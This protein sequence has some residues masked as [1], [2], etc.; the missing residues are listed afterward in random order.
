MIYKTNVTSITCILSLGE[1]SCHGDVVLFYQTEGETCDLE[2]VMAYHL[3]PMEVMA[4]H[5]YLRVVA[6]VFHLY[7]M[8]VKASHHDPTAA[9][10]DRLY[11]MVATVCRLCPKEAEVYHPYPAGVVEVCPSGALVETAAHREV[12]VSCAEAAKVYH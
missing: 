10:A 3:Y 5:S 7:L 11:P 9:V 8:E 4:Y 12:E 6:E 1:R 2:V